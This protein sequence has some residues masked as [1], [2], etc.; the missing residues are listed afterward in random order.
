MF[1]EAKMAYRIESHVAKLMKERGYS[2]AY[3]AEESGLSVPA[4]YRWVNNQIRRN[5]DVVSVS[6]LCKVL[7]CSVDELYTVVEE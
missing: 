4:V 5:A 1:R 2:V 6:Q 3:V 7:K